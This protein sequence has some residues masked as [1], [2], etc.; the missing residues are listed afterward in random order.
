M[1]KSKIQLTSSHVALVITKLYYSKHTKIKM[2]F[3]FIKLKQHHTQ[4]NTVVHKVNFT[5]RAF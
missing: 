3:S 2:C 4:H 1:A 5:I